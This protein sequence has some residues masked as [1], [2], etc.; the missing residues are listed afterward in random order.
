MIAAVHREAIC[1]GTYGNPGLRDPSLRGSCVGCPVV[2]DVGD[3]RSQDPWGC[4][5][6]GALPEGRSNPV[7]GSDYSFAEC[8]AYYLRT[9]TYEPGELG[10]G[11]RRGT[12]D[13]LIDGVE[14]PAMQVSRWAFEL[15]SGS[16]RS[17]D[18]TPKALESVH[19]YLAERASREVWL[20]KNPPK[21]GT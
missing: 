6:V 18:L 15:E 19:L 1:D 4:P 12:A 13:H 5:D 10:R 20:A 8:P 3:W 21:R 9:R 14:H 16:I 2:E 11:S 17:D 7:P